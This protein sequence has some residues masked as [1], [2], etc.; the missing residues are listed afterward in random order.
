MNIRAQVGR[1]IKR[2]RAASGIS[3]EELADRARLDRTYVSGLERGL[4]NPTV[5]VLVDLAVALGVQPSDLI[6]EIQVPKRNWPS[7]LEKRRKR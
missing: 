1:S 6:S 5:L 4:R 7:P 2:F 3:Q